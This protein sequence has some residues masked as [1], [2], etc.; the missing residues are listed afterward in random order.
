MDDATLK[1]VFDVLQLM[2]GAAFGYGV[3]RLFPGRSKS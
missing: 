3:G 2:L 1:I